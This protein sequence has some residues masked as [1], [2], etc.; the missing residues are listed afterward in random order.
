[1]IGVCLQLVQ[2]VEVLLRK[3]SVQVLSG[4]GRFVA[5]RTLEVTLA[6]HMQSIDAANILIAT[7]SKPM[8][9]PLLGFDL[10]GVIDP[11]GALALEELPRRMLIVGGGAIG[12]EF[13]EIFNALGVEVTIV[14]ML[15]SLLPLL[16]ADLGQ[17]LARTFSQRGIE[18]LLDRRVT[19]VDPVD[20][21]LRATIATPDSER[22]LETDEVLV[23]VGRRPNV[24][25][26]GLGEVIGTSCGTKTSAQPDRRRHSR[27]IG[28]SIS[29]TTDRRV[30]WSVACCGHWQGVV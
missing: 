30:G 2:G 25:D 28:K 14:E 15:N 26:L 11:T 1:M 29:L 18:M 7:G 13:A 4:R 20:G 23:A 21:G 10:L 8:Q 24:K 22:S 12:V 9:L 6:D 19:R 3:A 27:A 17:A 5:P 16:D